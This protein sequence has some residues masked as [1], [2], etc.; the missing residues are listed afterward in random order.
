RRASR[1]VCG[2]W[3]PPVREAVFPLRLPPSDRDQVAQDR[4]GSGGTWPVTSKTEAQLSK[5]S[6]KGGLGRPPRVAWSVDLGGPHVPAE[7]ALVRHGSGDGRDEI[8]LL[9]DDAVE[10]RDARGRRLW[11]LDGYPRPTVVDVRD[12][13]G[14]GSRG[15]LLTTARGGRVETFLVDGRSGRST[16][17]WT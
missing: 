14:D 16:S 7:P 8:L 11:R 13:A 1:S 12:Y 10:C 2:S 6:L 17:L 3:R 4:S 5:M 9:G 15:I